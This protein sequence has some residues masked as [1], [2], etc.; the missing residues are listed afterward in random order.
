M[1][2]KLNYDVDDREF[3]ETIRSTAP[4]VYEAL[5]PRAVKSGGVAS[6]LKVPTAQ[7]EEWAEIKREVDAIT[8]RFANIAN[9][10]QLRQ[11]QAQLSKEEAEVGKVAEVAAREKREKG[12]PAAAVVAP[13]EVDE[14]KKRADCATGLEEEDPGSAA[15]RGKISKGKVVMGVE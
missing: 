9:K 7:Q 8:L 12:S 2:Y 6:K 1:A 11:E 3:A 14:E 10:T 4:W 15:L 13:E 5:G